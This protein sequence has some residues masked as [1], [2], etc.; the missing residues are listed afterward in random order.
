MIDRMLLA[1]GVA[2]WLAAGP[3]AAQGFSGSAQPGAEPEAP[4][5]GHHVADATRALLK[6]QREGTYA[7]EPAPLRGDV[8]VLGYQR[9]LDS[10]TQPMP[11]LTQTQSGTRASTVNFVQQSGR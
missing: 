8:A 6:A 1:A 10:F 7:G 9:Y 2:A 3:V 4:K 5:V 11:G